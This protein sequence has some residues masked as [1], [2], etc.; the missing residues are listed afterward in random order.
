M[1]DRVV[2]LNEGKA[3][4]VTDLHGDG[5]AYRRYRDL[6]LRLRR[7]QQV[8]YFI[9][10][11][12]LIHHEGPPETDA[13]LRMIQDVMTL[14]A[15][16]GDHIILLLGNHEF[17]HLY[18]FPLM[19]GRTEYTPRFEAALGEWREPVLDFLRGAPFF[20]RTRSGVLL[21]H[22]GG[23]APL[24]EDA[25]FEAVVNVDHDALWA[26]GRRLLP[27]GSQ[28]Q[29]L[30][31]QVADAYGYPY[32]ELIK[33]YLAVSGPDDPRYDDF[34]IGQMVMKK[35]LFEALW[36]TLFSRNEYEYGPAA[37]R[38]IVR[39]QLERFSRDFAPQRVL[40][41]GH[42]AV[43][44]GREIVDEAHLRLASAA[45]AKPRE[46]GRGLLLDVGQRVEDADQ[47][48]RQL[49]DVFE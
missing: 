24:G 39:R 12:D 20:V 22:A 11:G 27:A 13:S 17:P 43:N 49:V 26:E 7:E 4:V 14:K 42:I 6:Y 1:W 47:L 16:Y 46:A 48:L 44:G 8:D 41:S 32:D 21:T 5:D 30:R 40:V 19:R 36:E 45:H 29:K 23:A 37:Y 2:E 10:L 25:S 28:R 33:H 31:R 35:P 15:Q 18:A 9:L 34:L 38:A 3:L